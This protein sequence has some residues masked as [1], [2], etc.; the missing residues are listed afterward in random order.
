MHRKLLLL[1]AISLIYFTRNISPILASIAFSIIGYLATDYLI[2]KVSNSYVKIGLHGK[3]M[4]KP[5]R[6][7]LPECIGSVS[8]VVYVFI[9]LFYIPFIFYTYLS[10]NNG[11]NHGETAI[12]ETNPQVA[13]FPHNKLAEYLSSLLCLQTTILLGVADDLFDLRWR[14]KFFLPAVAAIPLLMVYYVDFNV[15]YV[16]IPKFVMNWLNLRDSSVINLGF[17][18]YV[19][20][21]S[22]AIFCPNSI[23]ILAGVNGLEVGQSIV[24]ALLA[25][26][27]DVL[28]LGMGIEATKSRHRFSAA[29]IIPFLGVS[30]ALYKWNRWP[31]KVFV[32]D[33]YCYFAGMVF[34]V[35]GILGHFSK[36]MLLLFIPQILNFIYS[37]PQ[38]FHL[39]PCPRH[40]LPKFNENDGLMYP[41]M[42]DL[43]TTK[44]KPI[45]LRVLKLLHTF[46]LIHLEYEE[47]TKE[48]I[49]CS[50]MTLLNLIL[51]W[52]GPL[53]E[54]KLCERIL[55]IQFSIGILSILLRHSLGSIMFGHDNL[56]DIH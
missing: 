13:I 19:Y 40:R 37:V 22:M 54:D 28:Y 2:P 27:N 26:I 31:A 29:L 20:M 43:K 38:L 21:A 35:V 8:A 56:W 12:L 4:S 49:A 39:V 51:V 45:V 55:L 25:L 7:L 32:G 41:S 33:T 42:A 18:Y 1:C 46:K 44:P 36:T 14:H 48:I 47:K 30:L 34:A 24:L 53:R 5:G 17:F 52:S 3:D 16:L 9:M 23:N 50:N 15:T 6:P 10:S 11:N